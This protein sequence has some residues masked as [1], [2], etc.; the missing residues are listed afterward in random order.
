MPDKR[1]ELVDALL[2]LAGDGRMAFI[3]MD[4]GFSF[5]EPLMEKMGSRFLNF[6]IAEQAAVTAAAGMAKEGMQVWLYT[7]IPFVLFRPFEAVRNHVGMGQADVKLVGVSGSAGYAMLGYS[8]NKLGEDEDE[9]VRRYGITVLK[10]DEF[11][12]KRAV[13]KAHNEH[14]PFYIQV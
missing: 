13:T 4:V 12:V 1:R 9:I 3:T 14:K 7:M 10:P 2:P 8:H 6:G 5:L 11:G